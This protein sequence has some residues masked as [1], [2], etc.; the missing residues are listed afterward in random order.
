MRLTVGD[1][2]TEI[3]AAYQEPRIYLRTTNA[4]FDRII[5]FERLSNI[6]SPSTI[7]CGMGAAFRIDDA[8]WSRGYPRPDVSETSVRATRT[9]MAEKSLPSTSEIWM[10]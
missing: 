3:D 5:P 7:G 8:G 1:G 10:R 9:R 4:P 6:E 2:S